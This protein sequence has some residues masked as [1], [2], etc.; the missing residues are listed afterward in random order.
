MTKNVKDVKQIRSSVS[1]VANDLDDR[2][3]ELRSEI[4]SALSGAREEH[5]EL[6]NREIDLQCRSMK[7]NL[8]FTGIQETVGARKYR[9][10]SE[11]LYTQRIAYFRLDRT[12]KC[13]SLRK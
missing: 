1:I 3:T 10:S 12:G 11:R 5:E 13:S 4:K 8:I 6:R 2:T 7:N 9:A